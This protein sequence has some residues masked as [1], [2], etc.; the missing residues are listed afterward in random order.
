[1]AVY[2]PDGIKEPTYLL[3]ARAALQA[4]TGAKP[5]ITRVKT[6]VSSFGISKG[7]PAG[8]K[9]TVYGV[10]AYELL[11]KMIHLVFPRIKEWPGVSVDVGD[12]SG[13]VAWGFAPEHMA[14]FPEIMINYDSYPPKMIP[15]CN[16]NV[17]TTATSD[18][19]ARLLM[20]ALGVPF[21]DKPKS[22]D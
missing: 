16:V 1:M 12:E 9:A 6:G 20:Q 14:L 11:D 5:E 13:N 19:H 21:H 2:Q 15:G 3:A 22:K 4:V 7:Q 10:Q 18:R 17:V 8:A